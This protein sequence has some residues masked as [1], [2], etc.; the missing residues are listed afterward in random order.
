M[1]DLRFDP[2]SGAWVTIAR[3]RLD[4]PSEFVPIDQVRQQLICPFCCGNEEETP[5]TIAAWR[6]DGSPL[7]PSDDPSQWTV[8]VIP[9]KYPS[10]TDS[11]VRHNESGPWQISSAGGS[12]EIIVPSSRHL[13]SLSQL[14]DAELHVAF[15]A[16][17][18]RIAAMERDDSIEH[19]M[20]FMNCGA[21]AGAS[22]GHIHLQLIGSPVSSD[23]LQRRVDAN[24]KSMEEH[25]RGL[26]ERLAQW[27]REQETRIV[28]RSDNFTAFCPFASRFAFQVW[29]VPDNMSSG[30]AGC[31]DDQ[32]NELAGLCRHVI[33]RFETTLD[34][35]SYNWLLHQ[36]PFCESSIER[37]DYWY[38]ELLPRIT[39][40]A[41]FEL[42]TDMWVN[43]V[44]P[45]AAAR[46]LR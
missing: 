13:S 29:I 37:A 5:A 43:P 7:A 3:N 24:R 14:S 34:H 16:A 8:R 2:V 22:L 44:P 19:A 9:N 10:F 46:R 25:G 4:R 6:E 35:P 31:P 11:T 39:S 28:V 36:P 15:F 32:R 26:L 33:E 30:F 18:E 42:G 21:A 38:I 17:R 27:E 45:E 20:L 12:Q 40:A 1:S 23:A 41:G